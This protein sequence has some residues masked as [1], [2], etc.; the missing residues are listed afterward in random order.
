MKRIL[1][2]LL[3]IAVMLVTGCGP[4]EKSARDTIATA[5]GAISQAQIEYKAECLA[6]PS[7]PKCV[8]INDAIHVQNLAITGL[9]IY[10]GF[11]VNVTLPTATCVPVKT[12]QAGLSAAL[13]QLG[14]ITG[15]ITALLKTNPPAKSSSKMFDLRTAPTYAQVEA[16]RIQEGF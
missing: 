3:S 11:Q 10:C 16:V 13:S 6:L 12:A 4:F 7:A 14:A 9:E 8:L 5:T 2:P 1:L 15:Q